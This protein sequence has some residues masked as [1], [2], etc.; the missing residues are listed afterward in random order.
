MRLALLCDKPRL[1]LVVWALAAAPAVAGP[2]YLTDD[3]E[4]T[5]TGHWENYLFVSGARTPGVTSG[6]AGFQFNY[7]GAPNLQLSVLLPLNYQFDHSSVIGRGDVQLSAKYRFIRQSRFA[8]DVA[9][10]PDVVLPTAARAF[11]PVRTSLLLPVWAQKDFGP[12]SAFGG[13]GYDLNPG[14]GNRNFTVAGWA[15]T[16]SLGK[17]LNLGLEL[18]HQTATTVGGKALSIAAAGAIWKFAP[19]WALMASG[20]PALQRAASAGQG[21]FFLALQWTP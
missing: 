7:G 16:R 18:F 13:A 5:D 3:P 6:Q 10:F 2:P 12:W 15:V 8:P 14:P 11:A 1:A 20:G 4:P 19:H 9:V 21:E 17:R